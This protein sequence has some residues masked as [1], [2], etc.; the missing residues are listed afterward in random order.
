MKISF[1]NPSLQEVYCP[2]RVPP[3]PADSL[4]LKDHCPLQEATHLHSSF[5]LLSVKNTD[6]T[7]SGGM[8]NPRLP[9]EPE[10]E[11]AKSKNRR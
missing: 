7:S 8:D 2:D 4:F 1:Y 9:R 11:V 10:E 6:L 3:R 5:L